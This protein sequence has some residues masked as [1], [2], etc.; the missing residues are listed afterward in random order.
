MIREMCEVFDDTQ[1]ESSALL[2]LE[3]C[4]E[5][6]VDLEIEMEN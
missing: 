6:L 1:Y 3:M 2:A 5:A 4:Y